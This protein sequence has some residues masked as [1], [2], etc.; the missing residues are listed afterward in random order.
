MIFD[1]LLIRLHLKLVVENKPEHSFRDVFI[2]YLKPARNGKSHHCL[3]THIL[4]VFIIIPSPVVNIADVMELFNFRILNKIL[5]DFIVESLLWK[6]LLIHEKS[7]ETVRNVTLGF[8]VINSE[9]GVYAD[10][11][12]FFL[13]GSVWHQLENVLFWKLLLELDLESTDTWCSAV[14][15]TI[16]VILWVHMLE[17]HPVSEGN[18]LSS[19]FWDHGLE[20]LLLSF[21]SLKLFLLTLLVHL[22]I[23]F[24]RR[25]R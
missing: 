23:Y 12:A 22:V 7:L 25:C 19:L 14:D 5:D 6:E 1:T 10:F 11:V 4:L 2:D 8:T 15:R 9:R 21:G 20:L 16:D 18:V 17:Y 3:R 24:E 13:I